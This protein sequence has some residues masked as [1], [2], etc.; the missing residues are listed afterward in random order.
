MSIKRALVNSR[1]MVNGNMLS[2]LKGSNVR[3]GK[4]PSR[5]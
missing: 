2:M 5:E 4:C 3:F 1:V